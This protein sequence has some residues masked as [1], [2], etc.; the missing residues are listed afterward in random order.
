[1]NI[2][3]GPLPATRLNVQT[4][5]L[6]Q[7]QATSAPERIIIQIKSCT[8]IQTIGKSSENAALKK[9]L[10]SLFLCKIM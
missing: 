9:C 8:I 6:A 10:T 2:A 1:M 4:N 3:E 7:C 5:D